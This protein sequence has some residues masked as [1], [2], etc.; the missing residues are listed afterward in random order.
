MADWI[1][2]EVNSSQKIEVLTMAD[3]LD[4]DEHMVFGKLVV[5]WCWADANT[6]DGNAKGVTKR[7]I[8]RVA[9]NDKFADAMLD[10]RVGWLIEGENGNV[11]FSNFDRHN[12]KGAKKRASTAQRVKQHRENVT[13]SNDVSNTKSVTEAL[14]DK[15]REEKNNKDKLDWSATQMSDSEISEIKQL[16]KNAK[17][18]ITQRVIDQLAKQFSLSRSRGYSNSDILNEWS[19]KGWRS[20]KDEWMKIQPV[21]KNQDNNQE[22]DHE[23]ARQAE[24]EAIRRQFQ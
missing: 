8:N 5:L 4:M 15:K 16:R 14:P 22:Y 19:V 3:I 23:A 12:G 11:S 9:C 2:V 6:I 21:I 17:S 24:I 7:M 20:Y 1:K 10:P 18:P 13:Q